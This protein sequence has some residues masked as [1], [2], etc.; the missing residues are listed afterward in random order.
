MRINDTTEAQVWQLQQTW[1]PIKAR[2]QVTLSLTPS[3]NFWKMG[4][5]LPNAPNERGYYK[6]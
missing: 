4:K 2:E 3:S 6:N 1:V 5:T